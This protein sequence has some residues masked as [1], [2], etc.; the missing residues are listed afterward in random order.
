MLDISE[1]FEAFARWMIL[2]ILSKSPC[3]SFDGKLYYVKKFYMNKTI[4]LYYL[5]VK[6]KSYM[7]SVFARVFDHYFK[8]SINLYSDYMQFYKKEF[9]SFEDYLEEKHNLLANEIKIFNNENSYCKF[10]GNKYRWNIEQ[11][12]HDEEMKEEMWKFFGG[13]TINED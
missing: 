10:Y 5:G 8:H 9:N 4:F 6:S 2:S 13:I 11:L 7:G 3:V 12:F 1:K